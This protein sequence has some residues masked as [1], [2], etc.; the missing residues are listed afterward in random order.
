MNRN[1]ER[2]YLLRFNSSLPTSTNPSLGHDAQAKIWK[3]QPGI[4]CT[5]PLGTCQLDCSSKS[6]VVN[7][8]LDLIFS[9]LDPKGSLYCFTLVKPRI[10]RERIGISGCSHSG[11]GVYLLYCVFHY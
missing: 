8:L 10:F 6:G 2:V 11:V 5:T 3:Y 7:K 4:E 9:P 1:D